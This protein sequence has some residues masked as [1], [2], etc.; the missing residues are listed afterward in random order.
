MHLSASGLLFDMDGTL[1]NS[2]AV[3]EQEWHKFCQK[4]GF[5]LN[6]VLNYARGRQNAP[7]IAHYLGDTD[8]ARRALAE[9]D[10]NEM[11]CLDG[12]I[13]TPGA[14]AMLQQLPPNTWALVTSAG[15]ELAIRR[16]T[17]AGL[18]LP[19]VMICAEDVRHGKPDPEGYLLAARALFV[20]PRDCLVF[21][22]AQAGILAGLSS[23]ARVINVGTYAGV[24][25]AR[26][27]YVPDLSTLSSIP[28]ENT[29]Q[30]TLPE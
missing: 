13:A 23:G 3:V 30:F 8:E 20:S 1:V 17:A 15:R 25:D 19:A 27:F 16:M 12:V 18:P 7:A 21:E 9:M 29:L 24:A 14:K 22:D 4:Y 11:A 5:E 28:H 10:S 2:D 26:C 6:E